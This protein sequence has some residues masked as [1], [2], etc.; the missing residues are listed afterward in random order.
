M[1]IDQFKEIKDFAFLPERALVSFRILSGNTKST[2]YEL[3][4]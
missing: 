2:K 4:K 1:L 3:L